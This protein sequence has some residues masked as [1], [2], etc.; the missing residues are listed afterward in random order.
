MSYELTKDGVQIVA[1]A[2]WNARLFSRHTGTSYPSEIPQ[3][4]TWTQDGFVI[5]WVDDPLPIP[6]TQEELDAIAA[7]NAL[8]AQKIQLRADAKVDAMFANLQ[9][10]T[11]AE[12]ST[13][14]NNQFGGMTVAQRNFLKILAAAASLYLQER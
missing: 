14:V 2:G 4:W 6:P 12:I 8:E 7:A 13:Y 1:S 9:G 5:R 3:G 10:R 11:F